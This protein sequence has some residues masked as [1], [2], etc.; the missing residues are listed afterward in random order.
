MLPSET[1]KPQAGTQPA[2]RAWTAAGRGQE[3]GRGRDAQL[4]AHEATAA[5]GP[6]GPSSEA[7]PSGRPSTTGGGSTFVD[8]VP[9]SLL[10][11]EHARFSSFA[12]RWW[13]PS[14][15]SGQLL[16]MNPVRVEFIRSDYLTRRARLSPSVS[17]SSPSPT[18]GLR[19]LRILDVGCGGG[20]LT[21]ALAR[22][23]AEVVG[24]DASAP[25]IQVAIAHRDD[26]TVHADEPTWSECAKRI[27]YI[28]GRAE[29]HLASSLADPTFVGYD[30]VCALEV[31]EHV[32]H[33][34]S[35]LRTISQLLR[36]AADDR[37]GG[38]LYVSTIAKTSL[39]Y[40]LA[41]LAAEYILRM[42][43]IH[44]HAWAQFISF[45]E[46]VQQLPADL[47]HTS[48][49]TD[50]DDR[51]S[52]RCLR[53]A[54]LFY[55]PFANRW[56]ADVEDGK[57]CNYILSAEGRTRATDSD[58]TPGSQH[59]QVTTPAGGRGERAEGREGVHG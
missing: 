20:I 35:F 26:P 13:D 37:L 17:R 25:L 5:P 3:E 16:N 45:P 15:P 46:L 1:T 22:L 47:V 54:G 28:C 42:T 7:G 23:G 38:V 33:P 43:P 29:D 56:T 8:A 55:N 40:A 59:D 4:T 51:R 21:E 57:Q 36:R 9:S 11:D 41:I 44:T 32:A 50:R 52:S 27:Q 2:H 48:V 39:S 12:R 34:K 18:D 24:L 19:G 31:V 6:A 14:G 30:L 53:S 49:D 10:A 58:D